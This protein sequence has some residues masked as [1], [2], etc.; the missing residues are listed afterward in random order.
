MFSVSF[1]VQLTE[2]KFMFPEVVNVH[3]MVGMLRPVTTLPQKPAKPLVMIG[4]AKTS[5]AELLLLI[6]SNYA[7]RRLFTQTFT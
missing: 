1:V 3:H 7:S 2:F 4:S 5:I 6:W